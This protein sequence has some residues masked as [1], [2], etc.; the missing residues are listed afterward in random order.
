MLEIFVDVLASHDVPERETR[1]L[2]ELLGTTRDAIV[3][4]D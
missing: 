2:V 3:T 1:E 4:A